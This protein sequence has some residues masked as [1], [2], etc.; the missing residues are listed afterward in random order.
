M[1][2]FNILKKTS[3]PS[4]IGS[5][6][7]GLMVNKDIDIQAYME[8]MDVN[9]VLDLLKEFALLPTIQKVQFSN[10]RELR[11]DHLKSR[12]GFPHGYYLGLRSIQASG[13][14]KIDIWFGKKGTSINDYETPDSSVI[15]KEKKTAILRIKSLWSTGEAGYKDGVTSVDIY[16]SVLEHEVI[17]EHSFKD[18]IEKIKN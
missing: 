17:D 5:V 10:F 1:G 16:K 11:R 12:A 7:N 8:K 14:W 2:I 9:K 6:E 4:F 3:E 18:Y 13:E 15:T